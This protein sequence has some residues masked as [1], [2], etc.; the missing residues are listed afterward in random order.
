MLRKLTAAP[1]LTALLI[2][3]LTAAFLPAGA[4]AAD[5]SDPVAGYYTAGSVFT[6][7]EEKAY[8]VTDAGLSKATVLK[9][10]AKHSGIMAVCAQPFRGT[11]QLQS[12]SGKALSN[13][14]AITPQDENVMNYHNLA[15]FGVKKGKTYRLKFTGTSTAD[16]KFYV[17]AAAS[18]YHPS[19][20]TSSK[21]SAPKIKKRK[22]YYTQLAA[23]GPSAKYMKFTL[24]KKSKV[25]F[26]VTGVTNQKLYVRFRPANRSVKMTKTT[27]TITKK[28]KLGKGYTM[29]S[30]G[31]WPAGTYYI[32]IARANS[33]CSGMTALKRLK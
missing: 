29:T 18:E 27:V 10:K 23:G 12:S 33:R 4:F 15:W 3:L 21:S 22:T 32:Q 6:G 26:A 14:Y 28:T 9:I 17:I 30:K 1:L 31:Y 2:I 19:T 20:G 8:A 25:K 7:E 13:K 5:D 11:L 16:G 24:T